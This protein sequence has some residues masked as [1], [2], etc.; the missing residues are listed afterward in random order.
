MLMAS[1]DDDMASSY[2]L[3]ILDFSFRE[4]KYITDFQLHENGNL[5]YLLCAVVSVSCERSS[6]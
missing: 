5:L 6:P 1:C 3:E 2:W 4:H